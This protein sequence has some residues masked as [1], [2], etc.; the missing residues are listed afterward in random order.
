MQWRITN[1]NRVKVNTFIFLRQAGEAGDLP[2]EADNNW[3]ELYLLLHRTRACLLL[4]QV[5]GHRNSQQFSHCKSWKCDCIYFRFNQEKN[6]YV[7]HFFGIPM[8]FSNVFLYNHITNKMP[9]NTLPIK[10]Q[11]GMHRYW[12]SQP[13]L[14][15][16]YSEYVLIQKQSLLTNAVNDT[17]S[18]LI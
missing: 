15:G 18:P 13:I 17:G 5:W 6:A 8:R 1:L 14:I 10:Y 3:S 4:M 16:D 2:E 12:L 11:Q 7:T 9:Q